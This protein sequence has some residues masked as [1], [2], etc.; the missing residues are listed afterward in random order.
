L[1][2]SQQEIRLSSASQEQDP[3]HLKIMIEPH[4]VSE[5]HKISDIAKSCSCIKQ[6]PGMPLKEIPKG[7]EENNNFT[8]SQ[9]NTN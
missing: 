1:I 7:S 9:A 6:W 5:E 2:P 4:L 8:V 3:P